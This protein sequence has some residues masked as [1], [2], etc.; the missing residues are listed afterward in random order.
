MTDPK[1]PHIPE[2][3]YKLIQQPNISADTM[4][5]MSDFFMKTSVPRLIEQHNSEKKNNK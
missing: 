3:I 1:E 4:R 2:Y 5:K